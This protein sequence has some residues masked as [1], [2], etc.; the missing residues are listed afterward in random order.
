MRRVVSG[1]GYHTRPDGTWERNA[2]PYELRCPYCNKPDSS[3]LPK[4]LLSGKRDIPSGVEYHC[5]AGYCW[6]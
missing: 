2:A 1:Q 6:D 5:Y 3:W 4:D